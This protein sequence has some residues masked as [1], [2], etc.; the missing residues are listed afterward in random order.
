MKRYSCP[1]DVYR[2]LVDESNESWLLG[3]LAFAV[4]EEQKVE[5]MRHHLENNGGTRPD[6]EAIQKWYEQQPQGVLIRARGTAENA[7][8]TYADEVLE[9]VIEVKHK[10]IQESIIVNEIR[11]SSRFLPQFGVN[12]AGGFASTLLFA[13]LLTLI[14]FFVLNDTSPVQIVD[15]LTNKKETETHGQKD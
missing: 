10:E 9:S 13:A 1:E 11:T 15:Q 4:I 12:V 14:A 3:L 8:T 7:L 5:W 2:E 6:N